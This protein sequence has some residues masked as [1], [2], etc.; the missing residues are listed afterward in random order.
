MTRSAP[1]T[2]ELAAF[3]TAAVSAAV[4]T[5]LLILGDRSARQ[6]FVVAMLAIVTILE[7][8]WGWL[9]W[10]VARALAL[11]FAAFLLLAGMVL[12]TFSS[13]ALLLLLPATLAAFFVAVRGSRGLATDV[14]WALASL[15]ACSAITATALGLIVT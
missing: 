11:Y 7:L 8:S 15:G 1:S 10:P 12:G 4:A 13:G 5:G 6:L 2:A 14:V 3:F 9:V